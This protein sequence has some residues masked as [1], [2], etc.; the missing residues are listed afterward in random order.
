MGPLRVRRRIASSSERG[1]D[2]QHIDNGGNDVFGLADHINR[3]A[4]DRGETCVGDMEE[5]VPPTGGWETERCGLSQ[6]NPVLCG[7]ERVLRS[8][9]GVDRRQLRRR[10]HLEIARQRF[11]G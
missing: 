5:Q 10:G 6:P 3:Y 1:V 2:H 8:G 11:P 7:R 9:T 4:V